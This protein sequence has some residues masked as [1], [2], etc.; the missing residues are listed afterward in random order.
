MAQFSSSFLV[1]FHQIA[2]GGLLALSA[3]PFHE[4]DRAFYKSTGG[5]LLI[6]A[7]LS[8]WGKSD[9][10]WTSLGKPFSLFS[11][12]QLFLHSCFVLCFACYIFSLWGEN[13]RFRARSFA[14]AI[15]TGTIALILTAGSF[16]SAPLL[17]VEG[18][19]Y[20]VS[21]FLSALVL[22]SVTVGMLIGHWYLIDTGQTLDPF[23]KIYKFF[24]TVLIAQGIFYCFSVILLHLFGS[25]SSS[26][27][28]DR[29]LSSHSTL[30]IVRI[31]SGQVAPM[32]LA[33]MIWRTLLIPHT[34]AATGLFYIALLG[35]FVGEILG[36]QILA[37]TSLP[38]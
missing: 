13:Q 8:L 36:R 25:S 19:I 38:F 6:V 1:F 10:Y 34:M 17:S 5:V 4:L 12:S 3:T 16:Y 9:L 22:G 20:P 28:L 18:F 7:I 35:V 26:V 2:L 23:V 11:G 15:V 37:L 32:I 31:V 30:L 21:F 29:L 24:V 14:L 27:G 33:W